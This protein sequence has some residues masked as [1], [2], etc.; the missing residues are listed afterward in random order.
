MFIYTVKEG[1][2]L[3][4]IGRKYEVQYQSIMT[5]NGFT[6]TNIVPGQSLAIPQSVYIVQPGDSFYTISNMTYVPVESLMATNNFWNPYQ[7]T[8]GMRLKIPELPSYP[9]NSMGYV[10]VRTPEKDKEL[11]QLLSPLLSYIPLFEYHFYR[12]GS[13]SD[14]NDETAIQTAKNNHS[15]PI[16]TITN[17][18]ESGFSGELVH[19]VLNSPELRNRLIE[20]IFS[21]LSTK[22]YMGVNIDFEGVHADDRD[23][24]SGFLRLLS[25]RLKPHGYITSVAIPPKTSDDIPWLLGYDYGGIGSA[26]DLVFIMAYD[27]H[28]AGGVPGPVAP[29]EQVRNT[30]EYAINRMNS[31]KVILGFPRYGYDWTLV[32]GN[33]Y[34]GKAISSLEATRRA[35]NY[36]VPI[37]YSQQH[38]APW[39]QYQD[40]TGKR[41]IVWFEDSRS[42]AAK[43]LLVREYRLRGM[44]AWQIGLE[45]PQAPSLMLK[46]FNIKKAI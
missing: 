46:F 1:D 26:V 40:N 13:L 39:F 25:E 37:F 21:L 14:L 16:A 38:Q 33:Q 43:M 20:N 41:H 30:I 12:D 23:L 3:F 42:F 32:E 35:M 7:L 24:F 11:I 4:T 18:T 34:R 2:S 28:H 9:I 22:Q 5:L 15:V 27:W 8:V 29:V 44:G 6:N 10:T 31:K 45:F 17:L 19:V 36:Q